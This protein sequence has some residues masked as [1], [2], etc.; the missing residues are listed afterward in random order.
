MNQI[1]QIAIPN[2]CHKK[3]EDTTYSQNKKSTIWITVTLL[4]MLFILGN[5]ES[6]AQESININLTD[7]NNVDNSTDAQTRKGTKKYT[8]IIYDENR[9]PLSGATISI[10]DYEKKIFTNS[11]GEFSV[12]A[13]KGDILK[14]AYIGYENIELKLTDDETALKLYLE[15][16]TQ[17]ITEVVKIKFKRD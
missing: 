4:L 11:N 10:N 2:S 13:K 17:L 14:F 9:T 15:K 8:G 16:D 6:K 5:Q 12:T 7:Y 1:F 3:L